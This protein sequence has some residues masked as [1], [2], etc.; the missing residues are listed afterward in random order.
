MKVIV[1]NGEPIDKALKRFKR[2]CNNAGLIRDMR[3]GTQYEKPTST[4]RK[5]K[6]ERLKTLRRLQAARLSQ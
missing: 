3:R 5:N 6:R 4:R 2:N 1:K